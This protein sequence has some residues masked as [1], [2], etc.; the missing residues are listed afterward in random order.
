MSGA[1]AAHAS[2]NGSGTQGLAATNSVADPLASS[3]FW[4]KNDT[5]RQILHG[6]A[7]IEVQSSGASTLGFG[8]SRL[9]TINNDIDCLGDLYLQLGADL[10]VYGG[11]DAST[12][13]KV[14][15]SGLSTSQHIYT[16]ATTVGDVT[17]ATGADTRI[18]AVPSAFSMYDLIERV[19]IQVG[20]MTWQ[21]L[22]K[23]DIR[24]V[25]ATE[26]DPT[27]FAESASL[28]SPKSAV[29]GDT[30]TQRGGIDTLADLDI[31]DAAA[32]IVIPGFTKTIAPSLVK[33]AQMSEDGYPLAAA[34]FQTVKVKV[35]FRDA[36]PTTLT[37]AP[38][39]SETTE[40]SEFVTD[41]TVANTS[42]VGIKNSRF[43]INEDAPYEIQSNN[44]VATTEGAS[45]T[46][47]SF[48]LVRTGTPAI[49]TCRLF[50]KQIVM[51]NAEREAMKTMTGGLPK[52]IKMTQ[53]V[54]LSDVGGSNSKTI[55]L[56][57]FS[58]YASHLIITGN[59]GS[60][61]GLQS[62]ELKLNSS[63]YS[64]I[65]PAA[66]LD[67]VAADSMG[68]YS[69][70]YM[71]AGQNGLPDSSESQNA[72]DDTPITGEIR[73]FRSHGGFGTFVFPLASRA[74]GGSSVPLNRFD[75][76]RL[77][78]KF[79]GTAVTSANT[80]IN[81]TCVGKTTA[82]FQNNAVTLAMY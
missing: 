33:Y 44:F 75:S 5:S 51:S 57:S 54:F 24:A 60:G 58:L 9:F 26:L 1:V 27:A 39:T 69:N 68:L 80:F 40:S 64:S 29:A 10:P 41:G 46:L 65:L 25:N 59:V 81:V 72:N 79:T 43:K 12:N 36:L 35:V 2:Y 49:K 71:F 31:H 20:N 73:E 50:A 52:R 77:T 17:S 53:N 48:T 32:W 19:E 45:L 67:A 38:I 3:V 42:T 62:A 15:C 61:I 78:L 21:T 63:S 14:T 6:S 23:E 34:P 22:E 70:K 16:N 37:T 7:L 66:L 11:R 13:T 28:T 56:D 18:L 82:L 8:G 47:P 76:I 55:D 4:N 30:A 74:Y